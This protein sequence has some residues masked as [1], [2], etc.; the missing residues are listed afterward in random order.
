M[1]DYNFYYKHI[2]RFILY[3]KYSLKIFHNKNIIGFNKL[4]FFFNILN[5]NDINNINILSHIFFFKYYFGT[6]PFFTNYLYKLKLNAN[7][8]I[9]FVQY[10]FFNKNIYYPIY[11]FFNDVYYMVNKSNI[12]LIK[13]HNL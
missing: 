8:Y 6:M 5:I 1:V 11:F 2:G 13:E 10:N 4:I 7:Y 3:L 9:F 12:S